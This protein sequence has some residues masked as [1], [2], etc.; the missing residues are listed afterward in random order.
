MIEVS[1]SLPEIDDC[2]SERF[3]ADMSEETGRIVEDHQLIPHLVYK[4]DNGSSLNAAHICRKQSRL[5]RIGD[6]S[7]IAGMQCS[8]KCL[9]V[10]RSGKGEVESNV[11][12]NKSQ[13]G[14]PS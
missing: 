14:Y 10:V 5:N 13:R 6:R 4:I 8:E 11:G 12:V 1:G 3:W 2:I 9:A 7:E